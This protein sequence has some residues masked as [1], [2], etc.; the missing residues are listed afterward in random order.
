M[1]IYSQF[2][3]VQHTSSKIKIKKIRP[4][5]IKENVLKTKDKK[6]ILKTDE[7]RTYLIQRTTI[8]KNADI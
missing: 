6:R 5:Y 4:R 3:G 1:D 2:Q 8:K 7:R